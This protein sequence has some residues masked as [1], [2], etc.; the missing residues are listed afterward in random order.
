MATWT[1]EH[2]WTRPEIRPYGPL[3]IIPT[4]K[5]L[6]YAIECFE[7]MKLYR[8]FDGALRLFRPY[9]NYTRMV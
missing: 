3:A 9:I 7:G 6:Y 4:A 8:G 5:F 2:G 1:N